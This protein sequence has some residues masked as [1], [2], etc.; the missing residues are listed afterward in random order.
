MSAKDP[1]KPA[2]SLVPGRRSDCSNRADAGASVAIL[3]CSQP[4]PL[5]F[6]ADVLEAGGL[7]S[8][9][10]RQ[11]SLWSLPDP[12]D[13]PLAIAIGRE[14][15][16][17]LVP[18][19]SLQIEVEWLRHADAAGATILGIGAGAQAL[20][21]AFGGGIDQ[22][23]RPQHGWTWLE[24]TEPDLIAPGPWLVWHDHGIQLPKGAQAI[25]HNA[26][27]PQ[28]F[29]LKRHLGLHFHPEITPEI[30]GGW[31]LGPNRASLD[32]QGVLEASMRDLHLTEINAHRLIATFI[33]AVGLLA[34]T[35]ATDLTGQLLRRSPSFPQARPSHQSTNIP[36]ALGT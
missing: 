8:R 13:V 32:T 35:R 28:A 11:G 15:P 22:R 31:V 29:R 17:N 25:A 23:R 20:A 7:G 33:D 26:G 36:V 2:Q 10:V 16:A 14:A 3:Q 12:T 1:A 34:Y 30:L 6:L 9:L 4:A 5:G 24:T 21:I 18:A 19:D 27:G